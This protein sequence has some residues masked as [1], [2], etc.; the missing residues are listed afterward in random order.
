M[1]PL[2]SGFNWYEHQLKLASR[3]RQI[4]DAF[5]RRC[6]IYLATPSNLRPMA[7][8]YGSPQFATV[9]RRDSPCATRDQE[10]LRPISRIFLIASGSTKQAASKVQG[11]VS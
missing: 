8:R 5:S 2:P 10:S 9:E 3:S 11:W 4:D 6:R 7:V 1:F